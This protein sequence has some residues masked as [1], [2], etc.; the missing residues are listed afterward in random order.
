M[1]PQPP[2]RVQANV[3]ARGERRLLDWICLRL[4]AVVT[5]DKLTLFG[6]AGAAVVFVGYLGSRSDPAWLWLATLGFVMH[7]FGDS[8]DGSLARHRR[9]ERPHY[10][11]FLDHATDALCNLVIMGGLGLTPLV[12]M[13]TA[14]AA[15]IGYYL[16]CMYV[17]L[18]NHVT[19]VFQLSFLALGPTELRICLIA[20]NTLMFF[21]GDVGTRVDGLY[22]TLYDGLLLLAATVFVVIFVD[23]ATRRIFALRAAAAARS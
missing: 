22:L 6:I 7:W 2:K 8:L 5:P 16:L 1:S 23:R 17:F 20:I 15:L 12:R 3:L 10:G 13:D 14:L 21:V 18:N 11:Y 19:G 9:C 4:P